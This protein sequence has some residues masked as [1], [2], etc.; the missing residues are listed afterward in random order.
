MIKQLTSI[1]LL[2][3]TDWTRT[4]S[5]YYYLSNLIDTGYF[6]N[7]IEYEDSYKAVSYSLGNYGSIGE[8][9]ILTEELWRVWAGPLLEMTLPWAP[10]VRTVLEESGLNFVGFSYFKHTRDIKK[11]VDGKR[12]GEADAGHC[13][14]NFITVNDDPNTITWAVDDLGQ[15][16]EYPGAVGTAWLLRTDTYHGVNNAG[17]REVFQLRFH[18][19]WEQ[20]ANWISSNTEFLTDA[21]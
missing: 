13:C 6:H 16:V 3:N 7:K 18:S 12:P 1:D 5:I 2:T 8:S 9:T 19:P 14:V 10:R 11:H 15:R 21:V 20:V 4:R 17:P